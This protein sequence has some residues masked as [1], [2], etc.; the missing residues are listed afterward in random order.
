MG[1][2]AVKSG[3]LAMTEVLHTGTQ[4]NG[5]ELSRE[6]VCVRCVQGQVTNNSSKS[7]RGTQRTAPLT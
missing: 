3:L 7:E 5:R 1:R 6:V 2:S 4:S